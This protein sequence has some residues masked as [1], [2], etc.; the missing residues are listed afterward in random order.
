MRLIYFSP[1]VTVGVA[2]LR[3]IGSTASGIITFEIDPSNS[4]L[5]L[6]TVNVAGLNA[7]TE[8]GIHVHQVYHTSSQKIFLT[9]FFLVWR[10]I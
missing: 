2:V 3:S 6:M 5:V 9:I 8:H 1:I 7:N 10:F 4:S